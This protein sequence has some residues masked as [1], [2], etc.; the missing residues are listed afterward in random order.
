LGLDAAAAADVG[1][2]SEVHQLTRV[3]SEPLGQ[4]QIVSA[5][6]GHA[7]SAFVTGKH[8]VR[9]YLLFLGL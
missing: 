5:A 9:L 7:H 3:T 4:L 2:V 8:R 6:V 1:T